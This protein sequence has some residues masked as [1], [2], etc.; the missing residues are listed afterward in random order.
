MPRIH[1]LDSYTIGQIRAGEV[2]ERPAS[3]VKELVENSIDAGARS[4]S[5]H[6]SGGG[7]AEIVV[8]DDGEGMSPEDAQLAVQRHATSKLHKSAD[9][10]ALATLGFRGEGLASIAAVAQLEV[11]TR[12][13]SSQEG[14]RVSV[15][16]DSPLKML[17]AAAP[18]GTTVTVRQ[19]FFNTPPRRAF[20]KSP[21]SEGNQ[22]EE[23]LSG[24]ALSRPEIRFLFT[25]DH[26]VVF[27]ALPQDT[28]AG[29]VKAVLGKEWGDGLIP[30]TAREDLAVESAVGLS[31]LVGPP[32]RHRN[33]RT[34][35]YFFVN[36]RL[37]KSQPLSFA[38]SRGYGELLPQGRFPIGVLFLE[39]PLHTVDVNVHPT[40]REVKFQDERAVLHVLVHNVRHALDQS[41]L[42]KMASL[43]ASSSGSSPG[44]PRVVASTSRS[45]SPDIPIPDPADFPV[46]RKADVDV[47][48]SDPPLR[49]VPKPPPLLPVAPSMRG[50]SPTSTQSQPALWRRPDGAEFR[51]VGQ[52][53]ELFVLVEVE[54]ELWV[55]DQ[56]AAHERVVYE[57]V[58][59]TLHRRK[60]E[61][62][63]LLLP[64]T[65]DLSPVARA[66]FE[67]VQEY[68]STLGFDIR[69]F[70]G[71][72]YHVQATPPYFR[73]TD[74]P[75]LI[76]EL[77]QARAEGRSENSVEAKLED[78]AARIACKVKSVKAGQTLMP[79]AMKALVKSLLNCRSP[80]TCPHGRPTMV[81]FSV[82]QLASQF[83]RR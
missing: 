33:T 32:D 8:Q 9:L 38:F 42:F 74:T 69:P 80:F 81:R 34:G 27:D 31:G 24:L 76:I 79:E 63:P 21:T 52:S 53:H 78:L 2:I 47:D 72:T 46:R 35:Q 4:I 40:K 64:V 26:R 44:S 75:E 7:I 36:K 3:I 83:D 66:A 67:E 11:L 59:E 43:P 55:V 39:V 82:E 14:V 23:I 71:S 19:L 41:N 62:Q 16:G 30:V 29:R 13:P 10:F 77:A 65:F 12:E 15:A 54:E 45:L 60:G 25:W 22:I 20:L 70:G 73:P 6:M 58:L 48:R 68:L 1:L 61:S 5:V 37:V 57:Q 18:P 28:L 51:V 17:P 49:I 56:H 50:A